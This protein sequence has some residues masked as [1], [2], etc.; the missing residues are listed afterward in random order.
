MHI[1]ACTR[2][3]AL[4]GSAQAAVRK[5][6]V[7]CARQAAG[8]AAELAW[9]SYHAMEFDPFFRA[10][11]AE[12]PQS[13]I[14]KIKLVAFVAV[15]FRELC[16]FN[17]WGDRQV[18]NG[19]GA[20]PF[21]SDAPWLCSELNDTGSPGQKL[22]QVFKALLP[23]AE[24]GSAKYEGQYERAQK[25]LAKEERKGE[26]SQAPDLPTD[27][28]AGGVRSA[29]C[30]ELVA[31]MPVDF[32]VQCTGHDLKGASALYEYVRAQKALLMVGALVLAGW[33]APP[34][35]QT[36]LGP[37]PASLDPLRIPLMIS[38][39]QMGSFV[40]VLF[41]LD[42]A[43]PHMLWR[44]GALRQLP[45]AAAAYLLMYYEEKTQ[46]GEMPLVQVAVREA[47]TKARIRTGADNL[48]GTICYCG[49][50]I[51]AKLKV[52]NPH[53]TTRP[54]TPIVQP[55]IDTMVDTARAHR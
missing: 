4:E 11:Y 19:G 33:D 25:S 34:W 29:C 48:H 53:L 30:D 7:V 38:E 2:A 6:S 49:D 41:R 18:L 14:S 39:E 46:A 31:R 5:F 22:G 3:L 43:S 20:K 50:L 35:G 9:I 21:D 44:G 1:V 40:D 45:L 26:Y 12:W 16:F 42:S 55:I 52:D 24:G 28:N 13:K 15:F 32:V 37:V 10:I 8:R 47:Y 17:G 23:R 27:A 54:G 51:R 36:S